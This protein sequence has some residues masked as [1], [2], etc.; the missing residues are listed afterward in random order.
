MI[1]IYNDFVSDTEIRY[2]IHTLLIIHAGDTS[3]KM[4]QQFGPAVQTMRGQTSLNCKLKFILF[5]EIA[6]RYIC[7]R[8]SI[9]QP[10][11]YR[12]SIMQSKRNKRSNKSSVK[13]G[14]I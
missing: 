7:Y 1:T 4:R 6:M 12:Y 13:P 11:S 8:R 10:D 9:M 14:I 5:I 3:I 2:L